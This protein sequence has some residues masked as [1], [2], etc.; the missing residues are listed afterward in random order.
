M[1]GYYLWIN[2][3]VIHAASILKL[4][5]KSYRRPSQIVISANVV[6]LY[7]LKT[8]QQYFIW[9]LQLNDSNP[10]WVVITAQ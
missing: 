4:N 5:Q 2:I 7:L 10:Y 8:R 3:T 1:I 9:M 6:E